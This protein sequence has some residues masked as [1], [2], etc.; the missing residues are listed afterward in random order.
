MAKKTKDVEA[1]KNSIT[2][3]A[4]VEIPGNER[5]FSKAVHG[6]DWKKDADAWAKRFK[7]EEV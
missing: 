7:A 2:L 4:T 1:E 5:T 3:R 6:A